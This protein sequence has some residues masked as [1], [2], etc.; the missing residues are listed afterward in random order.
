MSVIQI[1]RSTTNTVPASATGTNSATAGELV[2][3]YR[4]ADGSGDESGTGKLYI[5]HADGLASGRTANVI[6]GSVFM[7]MLDHTAGT[8]TAS[9]AVLLDSNSHIDAVKTAALHIGSSGSETQVTSTAAELNYVDVTAG[10]ATASKAVVLDA[11]AHTSAV[12]TTALHLGSSGSAT[13]VTATA[14]EINKLAGLSS[15]QTELQYVDVTPGT[16]TASKAVVLN[17]ASHIDTMKMTNLYIGASG[18]ATQVTSTAAELNI[19]D[20][21]TLDT[22]E[23]NKLDGCTATTAELNY[24]DVTAGTATASKAVVLDSNSATSAVKTAALHIGSSGS[25]TQVT[26]TAAQLNY[27][28][29]LTAGIDTDLSSVAAGHTTLT[30]ALAV[31]TYVDNTRSGLEVKDSVKVATTADVSSWTYANGSSGVGATLTASGN[32]VV[33]IDGVNLALNDRV[34]VKDQNP[35][36]ENGIYYVSTAGAVGATLVLTR[37]TDAD[38]ASELSSGVFF[39]VEQ[40]SANA[41]NGYVMTQDTAITFGSTTVDFSQFSGAGQITAGNGLAKSS[42]TLS[43]NTGTGITI[44][45]DNVVID[46]AWAG[47]TAITTLGTI[48]TGTWRGTRVEPAY[49]GTSI[50]T[51][52]STGVAIVT[53]GTWSTPTSLT[54]PFGGTGAASFTSNGILYGN[55]SGAVAVTAAGTDKYFLYSNSGTPAWTNTID[56][57]TF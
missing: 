43:V 33:A 22:A 47:Q 51:S 41:D 52:S 8:A 10:T 56:G 5:G 3:S 57:G 23:L 28:S 39:F 50:D 38:T 14:A 24:V 12:K 48:G 30:S 1:K 35:A 9:S 40:G 49:G 16:A 53:S 46:T 20:D 13:A 37:A 36:T 4:G 54:V 18:S 29:G 45:S 44:T 15:S 27:L 19:L 2:Y 21:A 6:G 7:D 31:K 26:T 25:E 32:G 55:G 42:N 17:A 34:L 11:N